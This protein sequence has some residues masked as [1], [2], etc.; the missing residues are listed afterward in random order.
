MFKF[1]NDLPIYIQIMDFILKDII[2]GRYKPGQQIPPVRELAKKYE[3]NP[4]TCQKAVLELTEKG[5]LYT[6]S[7][8]GRYVTNDTEKIENYRM[9]IMTKLVKDF[10]EEVKEFNFDLDEIMEIMKREEGK[11]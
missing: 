1:R 9:E 6:A 3:I 8:A 4:N 7:T 5:Y 2:S 11:K 10:E